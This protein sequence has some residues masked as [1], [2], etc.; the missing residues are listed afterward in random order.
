MLLKKIK[1]LLQLV[2]GHEQPAL[3]AHS[4]Q[5]RRLTHQAFFSLV[6]LT[7]ILW[8]LYRALFSFPVW[9]D[10]SVGKAVFFGFPV[11]LYISIT[12]FRPIID[13]LSLKKLKPGLWRGLAIGGLYGF[14]VIFLRL[15]QVG[16]S[17]QS[18][19]VFLAP[20]FWWEFL[21]ALLTAFWET[22]FFFSFVLLV[23]KDRFFNW[24]V[25]KK[26][27]LVAVIFLLFHIP[28]TFINFAG[29]EV[30]SALFLLVLFALGQSLIFMRREN[31][32]TLILS[33]AIWGMALLV[34][35]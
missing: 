19:P 15:W 29:V 34:Y 17:L 32:Y 21:L 16:W 9:F 7:L 31:A 10:E 33:H 26:S 6:A 25:T 30:L 18:A 1:P 20:D 14:I 12:G 24:S 2:A 27:I 5:S 23:I 8:M 28:H 22:I 3:T 4:R 13:S 11:W 35:F